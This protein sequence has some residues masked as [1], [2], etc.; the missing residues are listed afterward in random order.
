[1]QGTRDAVG[2][3]RQLSH[4][5]PMVAGLSFG[6]FEQ[7]ERVVATFEVALRSVVQKDKLMATDDLERAFVFLDKPVDLC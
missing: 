5:E 4:D 2:W 1:M 6:T 3:Y 7:F